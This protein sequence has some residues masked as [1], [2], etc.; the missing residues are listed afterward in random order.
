[1]P[2]QAILIMTDTQG[3]D[4]VGCYGETGIATP[5]IDRLARDGLRFDRAYTCQP[6]C[7]PAR[8]AL[9][10][11]TFPHSNGSWG[12]DMPLGANVV[13]LGERLRDH[14]IHCGYIGKWHLDAGDYF[15]K[16]RCPDGW[17]PAYWYDMRNYLDELD[18]EERQRSRQPATIEDDP[19]AD[20][21]YGHR[22]I[23]RARRFLAAHRDEDFLLVVS[24]DEPHHPFLCPR[25]FAERYR[26]YRQPQRPRYSDTLEG[27]PELQQ[28]W[29]GDD[30]VRPGET[31]TVG[32]ALHAACTSFIDAEIGR[33]IDAVDA[34]V[35]DA[36]VA[37]TSDHG[38]FAGARGLSGKGP[39]AYDD[40][41][42]IPFIVRWPGHAPAGGASSA[43]TSHIDVVPTLLDYFQAPSSPL[44]EGRSML[45][46]L[47]DPAVAV[48]DAVFIEF[49]RFEI[50]HDG[51][52]G[53]QP[54]RAVCDGRYK[55]SVN[56]FDRD[57]FYDLVADPEEL[58][59]RIDDPACAAERDRLHDRL[60]RWMDETRDPF[61]GWYWERRPW[62]T[63]APPATWRYHG[64]TRQRVDLERYEPWQ[65]DYDTGLPMT[66]AVRPK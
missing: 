60:L 5:H 41:A 28:V 33:L 40:V 35:P 34:D 2:R 24:L 25:R 53:F 55:L 52:G 56:L 12:N 45:P 30:R 47:R 8:S 10:T 26:D 50:D 7:G 15:G 59:N 39:A 6:V 27:K 16:G 31:R 9:F 1:M 32:A 11:G 13:T 44:L 21:T 37:F 19:P 14:G 3:T 17:D 57:E 58:D 64:M 49:G 36:L 65:L 48:N 51:F 18:V 46:G 66:E 43:P 38:D 63:D 20:F 61:R 4:H 42:R 23:D 29:A 22:V 62:R 54:L